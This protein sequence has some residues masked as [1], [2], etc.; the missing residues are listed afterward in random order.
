MRCGHS[1]GQGWWGCKAASPRAECAPSLGIPNTPL[2]MEARDAVLRALDDEYR[3]QAF[4][5]A[6]LGKFPYALPFLPIAESEERHAAVL[7]NILDAYGL[8]TPANDHIG[9]PEILSSV[10]DF[11]ACACE[12]AI[13]DEIGNDR[14]YAEEL[15]PKVVGY[16]VIAQI[17]EALMR[18]SRECHL[19]AFRAFAEAYRMDRPLA[20][21][22]A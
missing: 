15:L 9:S 12:A 7:T 21:A 20:Q 13:R 6:V 5:R 14:L 22:P 8:P 16:P 11:L 10:P 3:A 17:F 4:Y 18:A 19:P 2:S 1:G